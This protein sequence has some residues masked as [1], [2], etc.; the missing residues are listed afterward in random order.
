MIK[1]IY[2]IAFS[3]MLS[4]CQKTPEPI[5]PPRPALVMIV[6]KTDSQQGM[7]LVGEVK[8]RFE[9]NQGFRV[10]GKIIER[11]VDVGSMV[12]KGQVIARL[13]SS[14][15]KLNSA[16]ASADVLVAEANYSLA[17]AEVKRQQIL[18]E[19]KFISASA[20]DLREAELKTSAAKVSQAKAR[21]A[22]LSNQSLYTSLLADREGVVTQISAEPGEVVKAGAMIVQIV[23]TNQIEVLV[24]V[25]ESRMEEFKVGSVVSIRLWA[26]RE[27]IYQGKVREIAPAA[28]SATRAFDIRVTIVNADAAVKLGMTAGVRFAKDVQSKTQALFTIPTSA[29]TQINGKKMVW[30][31]DKTG[32]AY[33][34]EVQ[35][36]QFTE[37]GV[38]ISRGLK[39]GEMVAIAGV[40]TLISGQ[41]VKPV[42]EQVTETLP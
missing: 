6:G 38:L 18:Y 22:I 17:N 23:D 28:N 37:Q 35:A 12:K 15:A 9:S 10:D 25:P 30:V 5:L 21:A 8:S 29:L 31:I 41:K 13:D 33:S 39:A 34:R 19:K 26:D 27:K 20:L 24:A 4:A 2:F 40:H 11:K 42:I 3:V 16:S 32:V 14:D 1:K 36:G 7:V